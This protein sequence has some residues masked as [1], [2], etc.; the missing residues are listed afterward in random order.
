MTYSVSFKSVRR[1]DLLSMATLMVA[2]MDNNTATDKI[3]ANNTVN[4][5]AYKPIPSQWNRRRKHVFCSQPRALSKTQEK[6][7]RQA[8]EIPNMR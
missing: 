8:Q 2:D 1:E 3:E 7:L 5:T 6:I 4:N